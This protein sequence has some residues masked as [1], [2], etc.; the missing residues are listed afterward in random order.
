MKA[1]APQRFNE[2]QTSWCPIDHD[3]V[4]DT[5][6][7]MRPVIGEISEII[8]SEA[9]GANR[10][11][12]LANHWCPDLCPGPDFKHLAEVKLIGPGSSIFLHATQ[13]EAFKTRRSDLVLV[14]MF[15]RTRN[16]LTSGMRRSDLRQRLIDHLSGLVVVPAYLVARALR[17]AT[18]QRLGDGRTGMRIA[19]SQA[20]RWW[21]RRGAARGRHAIEY[22]RAVAMLEVR[23][24]ETEISLPWWPKAY[25]QAA[26]ELAAELQHSYHRVALRP[27]PRPT[28]H[29]HM[30]RV[31]AETHPD[32][33]RDL[34]AAHPLPSR[35]DR[36]H[37]QSSLKRCRVVRDLQ[38]I[39]QGKPIS[40]ESEARLLPIIA[41]NQPM[42]LDEPW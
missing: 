2:D 1:L 20:R 22:G 21:N 5:V 7:Q 23:A 12:T 4:I 34:L 39:A 9:L 32:W 41:D 18:I 40:L 30:I 6:G 36:K 37:P 16:L 8:A 42:E 10:L 33:Y 13:A 19:H 25:R 3:P 35:R 15:H 24:I 27:A 26:G 38:R 29:G 28:H 14:I 11:Q 17:T 31:V